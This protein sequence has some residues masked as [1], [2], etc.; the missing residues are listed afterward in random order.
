LRAKGRIDVEHGRGRL[1]AAMVWLMKLPAAGLRQPVW[2]EVS[3]DGADLVW[4]RRI[5]RVVLRT[6]QRAK[7][8][9]IVERAGSGSVAF[10]LSVHDGALLYRQSSIHVAGLPLP[11]WSGPHVDAVVA[12][13]AEGWSVAVTVQWR[14]RL[15]CR[16]GGALRA[17]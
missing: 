4:T 2:L 1:T 13:T 5:G 16:Y 3:E 11:S 9:R 17:L 14:G 6:R 12:A 10:A 8:T 15:V 7:G